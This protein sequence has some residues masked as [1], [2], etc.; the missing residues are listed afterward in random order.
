MRPV[1]AIPGNHDWYDDLQGFLANFIYAAAHERATPLQPELA[2]MPWSATFAPER[3][4]KQID[5]L[6]QRYQLARRL[7]RLRDAIEG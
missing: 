3:R 1:F 7:K 4:W 2:Q 6:R 5:W